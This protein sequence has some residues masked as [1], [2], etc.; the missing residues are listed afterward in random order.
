MY[1]YGSVIGERGRG[2]CLSTLRSTPVRAS[3]RGDVSTYEEWP[4]TLLKREDGGSST[5]TAER[6]YL[7]RV[8]YVA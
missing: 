1:A 7:Q 3:L 8:P 4:C 2:T 6:A 5:A